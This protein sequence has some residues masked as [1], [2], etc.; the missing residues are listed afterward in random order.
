MANG[1]GR[2]PGLLGFGELVKG[3][4]ILGNLRGCE[5]KE[6]LLLLGMKKMEVGLGEVEKRTRR[7]KAVKMTSGSD[8]GFFR[9]WCGGGTGGWGGEGGGISA[10]GDGGWRW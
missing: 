2:R 6:S 8:V 3:E 7:E 1:G 4:D 5:G 9:R 10:R